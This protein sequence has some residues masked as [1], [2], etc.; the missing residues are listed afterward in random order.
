MIWL[1][2]YTLS[3]GKPIGISCLAIV[4]KA[5]SLISPLRAKIRAKA[6]HFITYT[7]YNVYYISRVS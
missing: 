4:N 2:N 6:Y 5:F 3:N 7:K 1:V